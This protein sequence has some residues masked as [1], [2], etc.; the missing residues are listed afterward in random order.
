MTEAEIIVPDWKVPVNVKALVSTRPGGVSV[1][2]FDSLNLG[3][4]V[5]DDEATVLENRR[6]LQQMGGLPSE[7]VWL[8]QVH[9]IKVVRAELAG[10]NEI[11]DAATTE[12][13]EIVC[14]VMTADCLP[15]LFC[16]SQG[17]QVAAAHA[18][19]RGLLAGVL[20]TTVNSFIG[21]QG[22]LHAWLGPA[23]GPEVFEVGDEVRAAYLD[24]DSE[25]QSA[26][27]AGVSDG[28]WLLDIYAAARIRLEKVGVTRISGGG[29][30]TYTEQQRFFSYRRQAKT[31]RMASMIWL[32]A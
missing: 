14:T 13:P 3:Q 8:Q 5:A 29:F 26:F 10:A 7:P 25:M 22:E 31:G 1:A 24:E 2:P 4:H 27:K 17:T 11:A 20:E 9:G 28:K 16:N 23:I 19:W 30:C 15:V 12:I 32:T 21:S 18:G 6:L